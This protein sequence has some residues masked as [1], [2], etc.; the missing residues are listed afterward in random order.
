MTSLRAPYDV[1]GDVLN[2]SLAVPGNVGKRLNRNRG[3]LTEKNGG[4]TVVKT[5]GLGNRAGAK[6]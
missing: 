4:A 2:A 5:R 1:T 6:R 3:Q